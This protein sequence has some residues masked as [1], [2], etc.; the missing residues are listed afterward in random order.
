MDYSSGKKLQLA[1]DIVEYKPR[2]HTLIYDLIISKSTVHNLVVVLD[3]N[4]SAIQKDKILLPMR[5]IA[6][7]KLKSSI[8]RALGI[9]Q[10]M[11]AS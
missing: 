8:T 11:V 10:T 6:N 1:P 2:L 9:I 7:L 5:D 3:F 4:Q